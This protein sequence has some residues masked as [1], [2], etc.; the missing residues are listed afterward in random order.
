[1][2]ISLETE[3]SN[4]ISLENKANRKNCCFGERKNGLAL[5]SKVNNSQTIVSP[6]GP[7][8]FPSIEEGLIVILKHFQ[9][10]I[11]PRTISTKATE[12]RQVLVNSKEQAL[13][14]FKIANYQ[15]CRISAYHYN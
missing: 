3:N 7:N 8:I 12:G 6:H 4:K 15:D 9:E 5:I 10:P 14:Y 13:E 1:M 2:A 11:F